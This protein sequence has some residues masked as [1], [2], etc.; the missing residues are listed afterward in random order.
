MNFQS[1]N[2]KKI[3]GSKK[4][5]LLSLLPS[6]LLHVFDYR[7]Y[8][9]RKGDKYDGC[10]WVR[11]GNGCKSYLDYISRS[12]GGWELTIIGNLLFIVASFLL[13]G[14]IYF[15]IHNKKKIAFFLFILL[16][17][18]AVWFFIITDWF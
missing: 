18:L 10:D 7:D 4:I 1:M 9:S 17:A 5:F 13:L 3:F 8:L 6:I 14:I 12:L 11:T 16:L 15:L 2:L